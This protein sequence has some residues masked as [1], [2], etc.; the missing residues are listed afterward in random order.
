MFLFAINIPTAIGKSN[1]DPSFLVFA[2][3][4]L[5]MILL[6]KNSIWVFL[7]AVFTLSFDS[8]TLI[9]GKPTIWKSGNPFDMSTCIDIRYPCNPCSAMLFVIANI[10]SFLLI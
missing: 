6:L 9:S 4:K 5:T 10:F 8:F 7:I 3:D 2:G 1:I